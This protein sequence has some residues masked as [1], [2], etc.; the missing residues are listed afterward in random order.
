MIPYMANHIEY[1]KKMF[2]TLPLDCPMMPGNYSANHTRSYFFTIAQASTTTSTTPPP[3][4]LDNFKLMTLNLPNGIY[5]N[6]IKLATKM[7]PEGFQVSWQFE[8]R[9]RMGK[10]VF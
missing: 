6:I 3:V 5:G 2:P 1:A 7:D 10:D 9:E 4:F 8:L